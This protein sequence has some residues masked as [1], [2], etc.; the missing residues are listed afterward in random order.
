MTAPP[1]FNARPRPASSPA[2]V[3]E[4]LA[5]PQGEVVG[6]DYDD[7]N[8]G[9]EAPHQEEGEGEETT[10]VEEGDETKGEGEGV[11][12]SVGSVGSATDVHNSKLRPREE[13]EEEEAAGSV[14]SVGSAS[15]FY[16]GP[17]RGRRFHNDSPGSVLYYGTMDDRR[18]WRHP[19]RWAGCLRTPR[20]R[21]MA[22]R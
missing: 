15:A 22:Q 13:A 5:A 16:H 1:S 7:E 4:S 10:G 14:G 2:P 18:E 21:T 3:D 12:G 6:Q 19:R 9:A 17:V 11:A 20:R 8:E